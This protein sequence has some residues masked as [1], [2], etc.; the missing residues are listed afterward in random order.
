[1]TIDKS[2]TRLAI[3][4]VFL[5]AP[6]SPDDDAAPLTPFMI[7]VWRQNGLKGDPAGRTAAERRN[8]LY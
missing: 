4:E 2:I 5:E 3:P 6:P 7:H 8:Y 1:M